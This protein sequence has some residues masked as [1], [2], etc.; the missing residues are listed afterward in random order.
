MI[1][2]KLIF[3]KSQAICQARSLFTKMAQNKV[4]LSYAPAR[5]FAAKPEEGKE[6]VDSEQNEAKEAKHEETE[7]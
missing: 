7:K 5:Y 2:S 1:L 3:R 6:K 4:Q